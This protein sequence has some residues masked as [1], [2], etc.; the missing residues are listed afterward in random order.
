MVKSSSLQQ[1]SSGSEADPRNSGAVAP[2]EKRIK[3]MISNR[4]SA[5]RSRM[6][7]QKHVE[8]LTKEIGALERQNAD[9]ARACDAKEQRRAAIQ[10]EN[11]ELA[12]E[13]AALAAYLS[14]MNAVVNNL[15]ENEAMPLPR[16][17][18]GTGI[19]EPWQ[20]HGRR[21]QMGA[22]SPGMFR[23]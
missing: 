19:Q 2:D 5:R 3:R 12:R 20:V 16:I 21:Q 15:Q 7:K 18:R 14:S 8:D 6:K 17:E 4:E 22:K 1:G 9:I 23:I 11:E 10:S 13:K